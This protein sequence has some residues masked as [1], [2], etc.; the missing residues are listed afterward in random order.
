MTSTVYTFN[1]DSFSDLH[2]D[3]YGFRPSSQFHTWLQSATDDEKQA[4]WDR[5][6][7]VMERST[8][9]DAELTRAAI[10][11]FEKSITMTIALGAFER[12]T[13][14]EWLI[15]AESNINGDLS[16]FEYLQG[17]PYGYINKT[18]TGVTV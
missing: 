17:I 4:E 8:A 10:E 9:L 16:Y 7:V 5:L 3:S 6:I 1:N 15:Q 18:T 12:T 14:V 13:A 11:R 2:K